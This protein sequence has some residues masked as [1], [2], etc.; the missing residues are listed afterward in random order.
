MSVIESEGINLIPSALVTNLF[1][2]IAQRYSVFVTADQ[3]PGNY[4]ISCPMKV[5]IRSSTNSIVT[6]VVQYASSTAS[7]TYASHTTAYYDE[8]M[9][10]SSIKWPQ[11]STK[12][13]TFAFNF[14]T[15]TTDNNRNAFV[16]LNR[17]TALAYAT[18]SIPTLFN[19]YYNGKT[20]ANSQSPHG[21]WISTADTS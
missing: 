18:P 9:G 16:S 14:G 20:Q 10:I 4:V 2:N 1:I 12:S 19:V 13:V 6:A 15:N 17:G 7:G 5:N 21:P 3:A 8:S 11:Q